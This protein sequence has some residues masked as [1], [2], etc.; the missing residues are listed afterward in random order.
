MVI[1]RLAWWQ[2]RN[3]LRAGLTNPRKL[4]PILFLAAMLTLQVGVVA[5]FGGA[6]HVRVSPLSAPLA[7][8]LPQI[9]AGFFIFL[10][11][12]ALSILEAGF[13]EGF[14]SFSL[15]D[16][17]YLFTAPVGRKWVLAYRLATK[18]LA[19][20]FQLGMLFYFTIWQLGRVIPLGALT[21]WAGLPALVALLFCLGGWTNLA[22]VLKMV[23]DFGRLA[24]LRRL[25]TVAILGVLAVV[26]F[27]FW[28]GGMAG[29]AEM[30]RAALPVALF[31]PCQLAAAVLTAPTAQDFGPLLGQLAAF[32]LLTLALLFSRNEP[33]YEASLEGSYR[34][35]RFLQAAREQNFAAIFAIGD[36]KRRRPARRRYTVPPFGRGAG[37]LFWANLAAAAKRPVVNGFGPLLLGL[38]IPPGVAAFAPRRE[39]AWITAVLVGYLLFLMLA[40]ATNTLRGVL[41]RMPLVRLLPVPTWKIIVAEVGP[42]TLICSL[43]PVA[44][45]L[46]LAAMDAPR[47]RL[48]G[49]CYAGCAPVLLAWLLL[50]SLLVVLWYP[51]PQDRLQ[52]L[53]AGLVFMFLLGLSLGYTAALLAVPI[54]LRVPIWATLL[55]YLLPSAA[56]IALLTRGVSIAYRRYQPMNQE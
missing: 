19:A 3:S 39:L 54:L 4:I 33:F 17:D 7:E 12:A 51:D 44:A 31:Y 48:I 24:T 41:A 9:Q 56:G 2:L 53:L 49:A 52:R 8:R 21:H 14:L 42:P 28:R 1:A 46:S 43:F 10:A 23:F 45:G 29:A 20:F 5:I 11:L 55:T 32:Y 35:A 22:F 38:A 40:T 30:G 26:A 18:T 36:E 25:L 6:G 37:A 34:A 27:A 47:A 16:V 15:A 13:G 50:L